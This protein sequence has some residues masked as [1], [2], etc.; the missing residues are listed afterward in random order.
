MTNDK[1]TVTARKRHTHSSMLIEGEYQEGVTSQEVQQRVDGT[2][3][4]RF[5]SFGN[6]K[7]VFIAYTD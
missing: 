1:I 7:F 5:Q 3:G 6:S 4:G 2:F